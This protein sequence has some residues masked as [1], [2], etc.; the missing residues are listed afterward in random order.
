MLIIKN[1]DYTDKELFNIVKI[2]ISNNILVYDTDSYKA[3][4]LRLFS[5]IDRVFKDNYK[6]R[7]TN[8]IVS[9]ITLSEFK[10]HIIDSYYNSLLSISLIEN[11][12]IKIGKYIISSSIYYNE[13]KKYFT[14]NDGI[15]ASD[16]KGLV[17]GL[18]LS[19]D[20]DCKNLKKENIVLA[21]Y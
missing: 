14:D 2:G 20:I 11:D 7:L 12:D 17:I 5:L 8:L 15:L 13:Y 16:D 1:I 21:S 3:L 19:G 4:T 6:G 9:A 18:D 10:Q